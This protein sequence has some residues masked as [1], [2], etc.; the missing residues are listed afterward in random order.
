MHSFI[1][2]FIFL[3]SL[4]SCPDEPLCMQ[5]HA[6]PFGE[7]CIKCYES[8]KLPGQGCTLIP[9]SLQIPHC[10]HYT[11]KRINKVYTYYCQRCGWGYGLKDD[12]CVPCGPSNC[13][14]CYVYTFCDVCAHG[15]I[16][17]ELQNGSACVKNGSPLPNCHLE[18]RNWHT[19]RSKCQLCVDG[20]VLRPI[21]EDQ[22]ECVPTFLKNCWK[23]S[24]G[25]DLCQVCMPGYYLTSA[26][27]CLPNNHSNFW[28]ILILVTVVVMAGVVGLLIWTT[29][30]N[31]GRR[32]ASSEIF[33][34]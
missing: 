12:I 1:L 25:S 6:V 31:V 32:R 15:Y 5:C 22:G 29:C 9:A 10:I 30:K 19:R 23:V 11:Y 33:F 16:N 24:W 27:G 26:G 34:N 13:Q 21:T 2:L 8:V 3:S 7:G 18:T 14:V 20:Y 4:L 28:Q 17:L